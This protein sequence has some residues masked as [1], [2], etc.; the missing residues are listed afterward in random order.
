MAEAVAILMSGGMDSTA[1][2]AWIRPSLAIFVNY[3]QLCAEAEAVAARRVSFELGIDLQ[4]LV[5]P[6][7][8]TRIG[9][10]CRTTALNVRACP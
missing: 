8:R 6:V 9:R 5:T 3:G 7:P 2:C 4:V 1:L 10:S